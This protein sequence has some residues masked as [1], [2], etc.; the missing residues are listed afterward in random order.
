MAIKQT[1]KIKAKPLGAAEEFRL[2]THVFYY[3]TRILAQRN[4]LL[5]QALRSYDLDFPRWRVLAVLKQ[6]PGIS[7][8][9]LAELTAVDRT[10]L[11]H[12]VRVMAD[13][14]LLE[15]IER[16]SDRRSIVLTLSRLGEARLASI[17]PIVMALTKQALSDLPA[18][19]V[20]ELLV[21]LQH[22]GDNL[23]A[24]LRAVAKV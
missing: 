7:M 19:T 10:S 21:T 17:L 23:A 22:I 15:R 11:A 5:N 12:T 6:H 8:L 9:E 1:D 20:D 14:G 4:R 18:T 16:A 2:E 3:L 13:E 24:P